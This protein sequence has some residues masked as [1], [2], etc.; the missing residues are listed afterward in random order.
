MPLEKALLE[1]LDSVIMDTHIESVATPLEVAT[2]GR[3]PV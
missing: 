3:R 1:M 2:G